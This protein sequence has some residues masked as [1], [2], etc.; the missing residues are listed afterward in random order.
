MRPDDLEPNE[1]QLFHLFAV[2]R[3]QTVEVL[4]GF[5]ERMRQRLDTAKHEPG[6]GHTI[7]NALVEL[8]NL[9]TTTLVAGA[10]EEPDP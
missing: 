4:E 2:L 1:E 7:A 5:E 3:R 6:L 9:V 8:L 10:T